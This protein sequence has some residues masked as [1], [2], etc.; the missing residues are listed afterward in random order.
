VQ[1]TLSAGGQTIKADI[2]MGTTGGGPIIFYWHATSSMATYE[3]PVAFDTSAVIAAGGIIIG[4]E[5]TTR[6]GTP[7]GNTGDDVW[8]QSDAAFMD[9][10][11]A[12]AIQQLHSDV[13]H[14]HSAGYSAGALQTV[15]VWYA[16]SGYVASVISYSGGD[17]TIN[18][19]PFQDASNVAPALVAHGGAGQD[20][21]GAGTATVDFSQ[22]S[23]AWEATISGDHGHYID[24]N[25]GGNHLA[26]F[27]TRAPNLEPV[28]FKFFQDHPFGITP[29]PYTTLPAGF[30]SYCK[31][32]GPG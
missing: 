31:L 23:A 4:P 14:I 15:Y 21:Y 8:Y 17:V 29:E 10:G 18:T 12:C 13:R 20:T 26:F 7:T 11:V 3:V 24:C 16:R 25:D 22:T 19:A 30:P 5:T 32:D 6:T 9:Q 28:A 2:W 1:A 27:Q